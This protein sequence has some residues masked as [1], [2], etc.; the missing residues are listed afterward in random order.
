MTAGRTSYSQRFRDKE[1]TTLFLLDGTVAFV[2]NWFGRAGSMRRRAAR[3]AV[4]KSGFAGFRLPP[5]V[6]MV[7]VR[8]SLPAR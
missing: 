3:V 7:A 6:I 1:G 4:P 8:W 5:D 2:D